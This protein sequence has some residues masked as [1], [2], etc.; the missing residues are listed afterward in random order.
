[1]GIDIVRLSPASSHQHITGRAPI[2][3]QAELS[4]PQPVQS[5]PPLPKISLQLMTG[6]GP[7]PVQSNAFPLVQ[8]ER[9]HLVKTG[10]LSSM[11]CTT[12]PKF[13]AYPC[14][15]VHEII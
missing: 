13:M 14:V 2:A 4:P 5:P 11:R 1:M 3:P 15:T 12:D 7:R 9:M 10:L 8:K 6:V